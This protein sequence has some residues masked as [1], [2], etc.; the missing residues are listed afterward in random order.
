MK[1]KYTE[2][3]LLRLIK[4]IPIF[5][6]VIFSII[7]TFVIINNNL[8]KYDMSIKNLKE[9]F[10]KE[11]KE[12]IKNETIK[13][14]R[15]IN[16]QTKQSEVKLKDRLKKRIANAYNISLNI[17][18]KNKDKT[19]K[20]IIEIIKEAIRPI[21][22][23][24]NRGYFFIYDMKGNNILLP[25]A[26]KLEGK[27]ML[28]FQDIKGQY[29]IKESI[30]IAKQKN[31]GFI[32]WYW[33]KPNNNTKMHKKLGYIQYFKELDFFI[34]IGEYY[35]DFKQEIQKDL[36]NEINMNN[37]NNENYIF[38]LNKNNKYL[39]LS[40]DEKNNQEFI[41][42]L[43]SNKNFITYSINNNIKKLSYVKYI[44]E[45]QW[46]IGI[47]VYLN[48]IDNTIKEKT[49]DFNKRL[50]ETVNIIILVSF[51]LTILFVFILWK[52]SKSIEERF[53]AYKDVITEQINKNKQKDQV[54]FQ[55]TKMVAMGEMIG[56]IAHQWRQPL[57]VILTISTNIQLKIMM[58]DINDKE[59]DKS[60][61]T[62][63]DNTKY[64]SKT[65][66]DFKNYIMGNAKKHKFFIK[67]TVNTLT[68]L[69]EPIMNKHKINLSI[70]VKQDIQIDNFENELL[71][72][73]MNICNNA[74]D[75]L[76]EKNIVD[77]IIIID[78]QKESNTLI[79]DIKDN[80]GGIPLDILPNIFKAYF[81]TKEKSKG[82]G[83]GLHMTFDLIT[84]GMGGNIKANN[85][86]FDYEGGNYTGASFIIRIPIN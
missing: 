9:T 10:L 39:N 30:K 35:D 40:N 72:S 64:L 20:K 3:E 21:R 27:N 15:Q 18:N 38:V 55:Q 59:L 23:D 63:N 22:Y 75:I 85:I 84:K 16:Y 14:A 73:L 25:T 69:I 53:I 81:T 44:N 11:Q 67:H 17:Y 68:S 48:K 45:W 5:M 77:K 43:A 76:I 46:H 37:L 36:L 1:N 41:K 13:I 70:N 33:Y 78:I 66:D 32:Q 8:N 12:L 71:Q 49:Q 54:I 4:V 50:D 86:N 74:K 51:L 26:P 60:C 83:L 31:K 28:F 47:G 52:F 58:N 34:G 57:S 19:N 79:I 42:K 82:T 62:I 24:N 61:K 6:I 56:N 2:K 65:I 80:A 29:V 7:I